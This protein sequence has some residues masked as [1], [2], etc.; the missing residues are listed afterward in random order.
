MS[1]MHASH[2]VEPTQREPGA[3]QAK[4]HV[5]DTLLMN[6]DVDLALA[7]SPTWEFA[8]TLPVRQSIVDAD[9]LDEEGASIAGFESIHHRDEVLR[10]LGDLAFEVRYRASL[11]SDEQPFRVGV[12]LGVSVPTGGT[13]ENPFEL[14]RQGKSHQHVFFGTGTFNPSLGFDVGYQLEGV[15][16]GVQLTWRGA[17]Y[18]NGQGYRAPST[19]VGRLTGELRPFDTWAIRLG[20]EGVQE[21]PAQWDG[22]DAR[23]SG[24]TDLTPLVAVNWLPNQMF[25]A[26]V[27]FKKPIVLRVNGGQLEYPFVLGVG[28]SVAYDLWSD[29]A[30]R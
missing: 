6:L 29:S 10:D 14:G 18:E 7:V 23:N 12:M 11:P 19:L 2:H 13:E 22:V 20:A 4:Q 8:A 17:L 21:W 28:V 26:H 1:Q 27:L 9:F 16:L 30:A 5:L 15:D 3:V 25:G 24:R